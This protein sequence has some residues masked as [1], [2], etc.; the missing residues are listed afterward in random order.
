MNQKGVS[1]N[2]KTSEGR[3]FADGNYASRV[4][5]RRLE[6]KLI[7]TTRSKLPNIRVIKML[8]SFLKANDRAFGFFYF[9]P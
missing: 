5:N 6:A 2:H 1:F 7:E 8:L 4:T 3:I 9:S